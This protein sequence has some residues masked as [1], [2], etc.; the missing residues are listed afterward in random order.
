MEMGT[1]GNR[2][3]PGTTAQTGRSARPN[4]DTNRSLIDI[5]L[6][7]ADHFNWKKNVIAFNVLG[8][9][10][11]LPL[12]H[13]C[14]ML[15]VTPSGYLTEVE[16][17]RTYDDF[18][19]EFKKRH[20]HTSA[21]P[22]KDFLYCVPAGILEKVIKKLEEQKVIPSGIL[23]YDENLEF[24]QYGIRSNEDTPENRQR[25]E[26]LRKEGRSIL[27][28]FNG[29]GNAVRIVDPNLSNHPL[30]LEQQLEIARLGAM[31]QVALR[32]KISELQQRGPVN[33][34]GKLLT[35][36]AQM[37]VLLREYRNRFEEE[38]GHRMDEKEVLFG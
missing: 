18:C 29:H 24:R 19:A 38:T 16:V 26:E 22:M 6:A 27:L 30:F 9:S 15:V 23:T 31:R 3:Q 13:E 35:K 10:A 8:I 7:L 17:K 1:K 32:R 37:E 28:L 36:I 34:D 2:E 33:P 5:E 25:A 20:H 21:V 4:G 14:D 11:T 12:D